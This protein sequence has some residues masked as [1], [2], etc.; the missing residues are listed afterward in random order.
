M[1]NPPTSEVLSQLP[2]LYQTE[3]ISTTDK[4]IH[5]H[6]FLG[7]CDWYIAEYD[8]KD[9][10]F[11]FA[12]LNGDTQNAEWGYVSLAELKEINIRGIEVDCD[13]YWRPKKAKDVDKIQECSR[14]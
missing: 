13:I 8:G 2:R 9:T 5:L 4:I 11:G 1:W 3:K 14:F 12:I 6:F 10:M 7:G